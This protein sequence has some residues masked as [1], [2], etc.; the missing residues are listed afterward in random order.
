MKY[1]NAVKFYEQPAKQ[2]GDR[3]MFITS[4]GIEEQIQGYKITSF[5]G[6]E[7]DNIEYVSTISFNDL[8]MGYTWDTAYDLLF[9]LN[10][11]RSK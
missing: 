1:T 10:M 8:P 3:L 6:L 2:L 9:P 7:P 5:D 4:N 11:N